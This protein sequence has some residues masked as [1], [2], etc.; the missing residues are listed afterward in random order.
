MKKILFSIV[1]LA[2]MLTGCTHHDSIVTVDGGKVQGVKTSIEGV[3]VYKGIPYAAAPVGDL[4]WKAPQP[5]TPW[6]GVKVADTFG[7]PCLQDAHV[8]TNPYTSE[9]FFDGDP[10]FSE[11]CLYLNV[12]TN[13]PGEPDKK[14]PVA[15]WIHGGGYTAGWGWEPEM[16]GKV[17]GSVGP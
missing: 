17:W 14:L 3:Y 16:D 12:W 7:A 5:V 11:D 8:P 9:F 4:R 2:T 10:E 1:T 15:L 6:E 13:A